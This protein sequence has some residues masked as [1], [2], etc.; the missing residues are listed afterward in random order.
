MEQKNM[1]MI[2]TGAFLSEVDASEKQK[3]SLV[4]KLVSAWEQK[5]SKTAR[6]GGVSLMALS[7]AACGSSDDTSTEVS[8][9]QAQLDLAKTTATAAAESAAATTA[10]SVKATAD[11]AA[12]T[13]KA[14][15]DAAYNSLKA[16]YD[17]L[18]ASSSSS[19]TAMQIST[20]TGVF[21]DVK[22]GTGDNTI[23][24]GAGALETGDKVDGQAG[25]D[26]LSAVYTADASVMANI[27][28]VETIN[29]RSYG[30]DV[31]VTFDMDAVTGVSS[32]FAD[33]VDSNGS[34]ANDA[35][36]VV[37]NLT[38]GT[39]VGIKGG[40]ATAGDRGDVTFTF[41]ATTGTSD[42]ASLNLQA[43]TVNNVT[44]AG[45]E[46]INV[47]NSVGAST[48]ADLVI[49]NATTLNITG[50]QNL[51]LTNDLDFAD[52]AATAAGA[53]DGTI[54]A[55]AFTGNLT[56]SPN[57]S[58]NMSITGGSGGDTFTMTG[59]L[60]T[61]DVLV[62]GAGADTV[63]INAVADD[64]ALDLSTYQFTGI[65]TFSAQGATGGADDP[66]DMSI[67]ADGVTGLT[68]LTLVESQAH[69]DGADTTDEGNFT[70]T[71]L[72]SGNTITL[73]NDKQDATNATQVSQ[74]GTVTLSLLDGSATTDSLTV[75]LA[76]TT[77]Q[78]AAENT[79]DD[80][81]VTE[82][83]TLNLVSTFSGTVALTATDDNT[84]G[85]LSTDTKLTT[86]NI[87]GSDQ[88][89]ITV[90]SEA[91]K[92]AT[93]NTSGMSDALSLTL[94]ATATQTITGGSAAETVAMGATLNN[95][96]SVDLNGGTD[97][98]SATV[99]SLT[100]T[101]GALTVADVETLNL[102]NAGTAVIDATAITGAT[103]IAIINNATSTTITGLAAGTAIGLGHNN[104]DADVDGIVDVALADATGTSDSLT[105]N[106]NDTAVGSTNTVD[107][108]ATGIETVALVV[109][110]TTDTALAN[111]TL[112]VDAINAA[113]LSISGVLADTGQVITLGTL[114]TD[115][116]TLDA[117][118][119]N[120]VVTATAGAA[121]AM[122]MSIR[123]GN[124]ASSLTGS[125]GNDTLSLTTATTDDDV[126]VD[127]N[128]GTDT[129]SMILGTGAQDFDSITDVDTINFTSSGTVAIT[130]N[131]DTGVLDGINEATS[132]TFSGANSIS[133]ITLGGATDTLTG[134]NTAKIDLSGFAGALSDA[135][136]AVDTFDNGEAGI[137][138]Q[139]IGTA[140]ADTVSASYDADNDSTVSTNMQ[141][142][143]TFDVTLADSG[144]Q[145]VVNMAL[146]TGLTRINVDDT[147]SESVQFSN[148]IAGVTVDVS[149]TAATATTAQVVLADAT[150]SSDSQTFIVGAVSADDGVALT[151]IDIETLSISGD[152][153]NQVDLELANV[154]MTAAASSV[155]VNFTGSNDIEVVSTSSQVLTIDASGM[156]TGGAIV[157][158]G[159]TATA[160]STYTGSAGADT[161]IMMATGDVL[162]GGTGAD[163][164]DVNYTQAVGT[165]IMD[166]SSS[167]DQI[168]SLNGGA[169]AAAQTGF[170][171]IDLAGLLTN[172]AVVTGTSAANTIVGSG[173]VDQ[174]DG[175]AAADTIT[176]GA[177][178]DN[179]TG[180]AGVDNFIGIGDG[181]DTI[182]DFLTGADT[183]QIDLSAVEAT[184]AD[185]TNAVNLIEADLNGGNVGTDAG[186]GLI[187]TAATDLDSV[188]DGTNVLI[189]D[190][191]IANEAAL[192]TAL[193]IGGTYALTLGAALANDT[194]ILTIFSNG[195]DAFLTLVSN[196]SGSTITDGDT[197][198]TAE[199]STD[200]LA[201][202]SGVA[203]GG[204]IADANIGA[205]V[206]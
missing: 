104:V 55:G 155:A 14:T 188:T 73:Q 99:T 137:S 89:A 39:E 68:S 28:N 101:T 187:L 123:G 110:D 194:G 62:G 161:F 193:A 196:I 124:A 82:V 97:V 154:T 133:T 206:A 24:A 23:S 37:N 135:T 130:T 115:T 27:S 67:A 134:T 98:L 75:N 114:D 42:S 143:E 36:V 95:S 107:L 169:N 56:V 116:D 77:A 117:S 6:A 146:T 125:S 19:S 129:L 149:A 92:L 5:N 178:A 100:A 22:A 20:T 51:T 108:R 204:S 64:A 165:A 163:T 25:T 120:G 179:L 202:F 52:T 158:T 34:G 176:G 76:G 47:A 85:D 41:S 71:G 13:A 70:V 3:N 147:S 90:G 103:E 177:G 88:A 59:G 81:A 168:A 38:L 30:A 172:G 150:G 4:S 128:G 175:G 136:F 78:S 8:Y 159:R 189:L 106:L 31:D 79:V 69:A 164:L 201:T 191:T 60:D 10:V 174:I 29:V 186:V 65:E 192:E 171:H 198:T 105:I 53:I 200:I 140:N 96:D 40:T 46:T 148:L 182:T 1:N 151:T 35:S 152:T 157:Q 167:T 127:G 160:A 173:L 33:R 45:I 7:L 50:S 9:T 205:F 72:T 199:I 118:G 138:V 57:A 113:T 153:A 185:G 142:V 11:A 74:I 203:D 145:T 84:L 12:I 54:N 181:A 93:V 156:S 180:G 58:D 15:A 26:I 162:A 49:A 87:S 94:Q 112:D 122:T 109:T 16:T 66:I 44:L 166:L 2:S 83:E 91:T 21:D 48:L 17:A 190:N 139:V 63:S 86:L 144:T 61:N 131:A 121:N 111:V 197:L 141:G 126:T 184:T 43:A 18:V 183:I 170:Q 32:F 119:Y 102:T 195:T 132:V 80:L